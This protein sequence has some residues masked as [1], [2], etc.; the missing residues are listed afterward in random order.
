M[1]SDFSDLLGLI[2][3]Q[4]WASVGDHGR[5]SRWGS[6]RLSARKVAPWDLK[7]LKSAPSVSRVQGKVKAKGTD[8][9]S[10]FLVKTIGCFSVW[11]SD[12]S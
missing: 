3:A 2:A 10:R 7:L 9:G 4:G 1:D 11:V 8:R 5:G 6:G 12:E